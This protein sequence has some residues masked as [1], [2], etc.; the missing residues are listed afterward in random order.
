ML[1]PL[2]GLTS[3]KVKFKW[4]DIENKDFDEVK[5]IVECNNLFSYPDCNKK[6]YIHNDARYLQLVEV[7]SQEVRPITFCNIKV[8][9]H[10]RGIE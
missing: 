5:R 2:T 6:F 7:I 10:R 8:T 4:T 3:S 9:V 1:K